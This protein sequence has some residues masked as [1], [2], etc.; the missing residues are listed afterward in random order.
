MP[1]GRGRAFECPL[2]SSIGLFQVDV[3]VTG[4]KTRRCLCSA[5]ARDFIVGEQLQDGVTSYVLGSLVVLH[6]GSGHGGSCL[7]PR[8]VL[9]FALRMPQLEFSE[10]ESTERSVRSVLVSLP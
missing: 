1:H 10:N 4:R 2:H 8:D 5:H 9:C 7:L 6:R 3:L